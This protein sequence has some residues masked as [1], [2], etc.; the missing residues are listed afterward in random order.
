MSERLGVA[1][2]ELNI[3]NPVALAPSKARLLVFRIKGGRCVLEEG[4]VDALKRVDANHGIGLPVNVAGDDR[5]NTAFRTDVEAGRLRAENIARD[6]GCI[7][8]RYG[9]STGRAGSPY[10]A[11]FGAERTGTGTRRNFGRFWFPE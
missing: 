3:W 11:M 6:M 1:V 8:D 4:T 2:A 7:G 5:H 9:K 10:S